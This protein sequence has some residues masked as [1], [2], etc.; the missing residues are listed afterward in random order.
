MKTL[1]ASL[2]LTASLAFS[3]VSY[4]QSETTASSLAGE[5]TET[6][7]WVVTTA[8]GKIEVN[9]I[10]AEKEVSVNVVD[11][12]GHTLASKVIDKEDAATRTKFDLS[13]LPDGSYKVV[14]IDGKH[15]AVKNIE[16]NTRSVEAQRVVSVG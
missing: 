7:F 6:R 1:I 10:K 9:V 4:A 2:F 8:N 15:K 5:G 3:S 13:Q 16:L 12:F 14:L 11:Q